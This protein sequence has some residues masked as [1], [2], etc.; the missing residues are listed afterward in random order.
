MCLLCHTLSVRKYH[1]SLCRSVL[2][3]RES[4]FLKVD[5][6]G[7]GGVCSV[8]RWLRNQRMRSAHQGDGVISIKQ[9]SPIKEHTPNS[10]FTPRPIRPEGYCHHP[11]LSVCPSVRPSVCPSVRLSVCYPKLVRA[12][13]Q[14]R[15][16]G[17]SPNLHTRCI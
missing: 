16:D 13:S 1:Y 14:K 2:R 15:I 5:C 3:P 17:S 9:I 7:L 10:V 4:Q 11:C 12:I 6:T 8:A